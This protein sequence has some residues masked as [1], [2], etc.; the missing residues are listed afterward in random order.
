MRENRRLLTGLAI[1]VALHVMAFGFVR[2]SSTGPGWSPDRDL[3]VLESNSW[4]GTPVDVFFGPPKIFRAD[5]ATSEE[6]PDRVLE[7]ARLLGMPPTCMSRE[8][9][10]RGPG[11]GQVRLTVNANGRIDAV[12][13]D[14]S[15]GD[16]CWDAVAMRVAGDLWYQWLPNARFPAPVELLQPITVGLAQE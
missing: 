8:I 3:V 6:P 4:T 7:A 16:S 2:W 11:S 9:P 13:L 15:T 1:A 10:P 5:G 14:Q 12:S